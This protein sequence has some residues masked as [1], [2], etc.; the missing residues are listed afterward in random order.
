MHSKLIRL[1]FRQSSTD[2]HLY[3]YSSKSGT[4]IL[5]IVVD[6]ILTACNSYS[7]LQDFKAEMKSLFKL[8]VLGEVKS[9][10]GLQIKRDEKGIMVTQS[11]YTEKIIKENR[12][13]NSNVSQ[14]LLPTKED[15]TRRRQ[16]KRAVPTATH[17][18]YR[19][20]VGHLMYFAVRSRPENMFA[21]SMLARQVHDPFLRHV[22]LPKRDL[23]Y[24]KGTKGLGLFYP[25][26][27]SAPMEAFCEAN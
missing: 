21:A 16:E 1:R 11:R 17:N 10:V 3:M 19:K 8:K 5:V 20:L 24:L 27:Y 23:W 4:L 15:M 22:G 9:L 14:T 26:S 2:S 18:R 25:S 6:D 12:L 13:E 7:L